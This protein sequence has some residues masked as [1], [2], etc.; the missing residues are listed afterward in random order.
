[1]ALFP[2]LSVLLFFI[3]KGNGLSEPAQRISATLGGATETVGQCLGEQ[4]GVIGD[5]EVEI[6][7]LHSCINPSIS[8]LICLLHWRFH[9]NK[10]SSALREVRW[11]PVAAAPSRP[12]PEGSWPPIYIWLRPL[13]DPGCLSYLGLL[14]VSSQRAENWDLA[15][16][17][18]SWCYQCGLWDGA[19][20]PCKSDFLGGCKEI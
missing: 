14:Q 8:A 11:S 5:T 10:A 20:G 9:L 18:E 19:T 7:D 6:W 3:P 15:S 4:R 12:L 17:Q 16:G 1:M 2:E 13:C